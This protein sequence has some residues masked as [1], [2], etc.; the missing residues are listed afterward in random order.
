MKTWLKVLIVTVVVAIPAFLAEPNSPLGVFWRPPAGGPEP[1]GAQVPLFIVLGVL[2]AVMLGLGVS[3]LI[4]GY[5]LIR[6]IGSAS[7]GRTLAA[8]LSLSWVLLQWWPHDSLHIWAS[9]ILG[10]GD[11]WKILAIDYIF[12]VTIMIA[13]LIAVSF[14]IT[15]IRHARTAT[16]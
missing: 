15:I 4:F 7:R 5:P 14:F 12:H 9:R 3:F 6:A 2:D 16:N 11:L 13:S 8:Y 1:Q 10:T